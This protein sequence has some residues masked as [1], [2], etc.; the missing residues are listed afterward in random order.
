MEGR[1]PV[2]LVETK[3]WSALLGLRGTVGRFKSSG[4]SLAGRI[5]AALGGPKSRSVRLGTSL[6]RRAFSWAGGGGTVGE[7]F[8]FL[9]CA[10]KI[11]SW[12]TELAPHQARRA[13]SGETPALKAFERG[14]RGEEGRGREVGE[15]SVL[16]LV[17]GGLRNAGTSRGLITP[18]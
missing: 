15:R 4:G 3:D 7:S 13:M 9:L 18:E 2:V 5:F 16:P 11:P 8:C 6:K 1:S 14:E 17:G 12:S 10:F